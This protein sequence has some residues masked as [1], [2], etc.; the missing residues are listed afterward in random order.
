[1][2]I[3]SWS[4]TKKHIANAIASF[5]TAALLSTS[6]IK[7]ED[8]PALPE[9]QPKILSTEPGTEKEKE[10][11]YD[12]GDDI[13]RTIQKKNSDASLIIAR[14]EIDILTAELDCAL[15]ALAGSKGEINDLK[16]TLKSK[17]SSLAKLQLHYDL[18][19]AEIEAQE[20]VLV[21]DKEIIQSSKFTGKSSSDE[22]SQPDDDEVTH[23]NHHSGRPTCS[24]STDPSKDTLSV[25]FKDT[26]SLDVDVKFADFKTIPDLAI[27]PT[28]STSIC[29]QSSTTEGSI[30]DKVCISDKYYPRNLDDEDEDDDESTSKA[31]LGRRKHFSSSSSNP[32][33]SLTKPK[34]VLRPAASGFPFI[35]VDHMADQ[36]GRISP[37]SD[38]SGGV[39][40]RLGDITI[41][42]IEADHT[43]S[44]DMA[45]I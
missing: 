25:R 4:N 23:C 27:A 17:E 29:S 42:Y 21:E 20:D 10:E 11:H 6:Q 8:L 2:N 15:K 44:S 3:I 41:G 19:T 13:M 37:L 18:L 45:E 39:R 30:I 16:A 33:K 36:G 35:K 7:M 22:Y 28:E 31:L 43:F 24:T 12:D 1:M 9:E 5:F 34:A 40:D 32:L 38:C 26:S 14:N